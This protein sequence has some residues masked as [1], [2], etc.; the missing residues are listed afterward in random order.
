ITTPALV[1]VGEEDPGTTVA[2]A[3]DIQSRIAGSNLVVLPEAAHFSN[4]E[5]AGPFN[6]ALL[7]FLKP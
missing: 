4:M 1:M 5:Q 2:M 3:Q 7:E 6:E